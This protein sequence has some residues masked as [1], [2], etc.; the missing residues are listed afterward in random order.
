MSTR[1]RGRPKKAYLRKALS[2]YLRDDEREAIDAVRGLRDRSEWIREAIQEKL[3]RER[4][5]TTDETAG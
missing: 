4:K 5:H 2:L 3:R 1:K